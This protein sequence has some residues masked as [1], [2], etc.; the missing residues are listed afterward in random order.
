MTARTAH[1]LVAGPRKVA[2]ALCSVA[3]LGLAGCTT[4]PDNSAPTVVQR[5][6]LQP[7]AAAPSGPPS[8]AEPREI[9]Q[10]FLTANGTA[11]PH[12]VG[13][14]LY[15]TP[16]ERT[17]WSDL[18]T[19]VV[20]NTQVRNIALD[21]HP[22][23]P[24][25]GTITVTGR[26]IG[27]IDENGVYKPF[28]R[29]NGSGLG[30]VEFSQTYHLISSHGQW[31]IDSVPAGL[32]VTSAQ[33]QAFHQYAV[34]FFDSAEQDLVPVPRYTQ[35]ADPRDVVPWLVQDQL[36]GQ[37]PS[38]LQSGLPSNDTNKI[39]VSYPADPTQPISIE[40]PGASAL[41]GANLNRLAAQVSA[42][43][44]QV[45]Q[46]DLIQITD[47]GQPVRIPA[48]N[49]S[50]F[51][52]GQLSGR[53]QP[54]PPSNLLYYVHGGA[55]YQEDGRRIPGKIGAGVYGLT[56]AALT[57][58]SGGALQVAGV[59][60]SGSQQVL[61][62]PNPKVPG[63]LVPTSVHGALSRPTWAPGR[64]EVWIGDGSDLER[65]T[66][67]RSVQTVQLD[68]SAGKASG[69][70]RAV[71]VSPDGGRVALV[72]ASAGTSQIYVGDIV[73]SQNQVSVNN[74][75]PI[76]PQ[77]VAVTDVAWNDQFKLFATGHD[78]TI[79]DS[80][81]YEVLCDGSL[82]TPGG[83]QGLPGA[84]EAVTAASG[85]EA[86]VSSGDTLYQQQGSQWRGL[87]NG[88]TPGSNPVYLE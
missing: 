73:R 57:T 7:A 86:V 68:V 85:S 4:V 64:R 82:W 34:Y 62:I 1:R 74:L 87:L 26:E 81:V 21:K 41:D 28:L 38:E 31:R 71:R 49:A 72:L 63:S 27:T 55:V 5:V 52:V 23:G 35:R 9:V 76:S 20:D 12:H 70:V 16:Q 30:G 24:A 29:G 22:A 58:G 66:G 3:V 43:L 33:F 59:R 78:M 65:V 67:P 15:L 44:Q 80:Q 40:I 46:V 6:Q 10:G 51:P 2:L 53:Y 77:G 60:Q 42:T 18:T 47:G 14:R 88:E 69:Q 19:T 25:G 50:A 83:D 36:A 84:P 13:A 45:L 17:R 8:G 48:V 37:P 54:V 61:D 11:D 39:A 56:S 75:Q 79:G 32:L